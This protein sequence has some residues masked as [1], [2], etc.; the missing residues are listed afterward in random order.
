MDGWTGKPTDGPIDGPTNRVTYRVAWTHLKSW[1]FEINYCK[2]SLASGSDE[3]A[4][5]EE[6]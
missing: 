6:V 5:I 3:M 4:A 1:T 2:V